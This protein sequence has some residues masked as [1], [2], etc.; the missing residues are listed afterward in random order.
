[1][2]SKIALAQ[3]R[4]MLVYGWC[5]GAVWSVQQNLSSYTENL[6]NEEK[7]QYREKIGVIGGLDP[8]GGCPGEPCKEFLPVKAS[9]LVAYLD[10]QT[11]LSPLN[12]SR[13]TNESRMPYWCYKSLSEFSKVHMLPRIILFYI[14]GNHMVASTTSLHKICTWRH[15]NQNIQM[16]Q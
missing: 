1:M 3:A 10:L 4:T 8:F 16:L 14:P 12:N 2:W 13:H 9:D 7:T 6:S 11:T 15:K 5:T